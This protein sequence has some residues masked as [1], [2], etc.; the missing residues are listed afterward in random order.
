MKRISST[1]I[2]LSFILL[3]IGL[4]SFSIDRN[5]DSGIASLKDSFPEENSFGMRV[6]KVPKKAGSIHQP[7]IVAK[8]PGNEATILRTSQNEIK[9]FFVNRPGDA[10]KLMSVSSADNGLSWTAARKEFDLPGQA[11]YANALL[12]DA[13]GNLH[14]IFHIFGEGKNGYR[15]RHLNLWYCHTLNNGKDWSEPTE[16]YHG[17]VG[18]I[19]GFIQLKNK[20]FLLV[21]A[22]AI[23]ARSQKPSNNSTDYGLHDIGALYSDN[24]GK[25][26]QSSEND[27]KIPIESTQ[28]TRYG[29][30]EP[31]IIELSDGKI[32]MLI[33]TNKG[34]TYQSFSTDSGTRWHQPEPTKFISSDSPAAT[35]RLA[36][37][38]IV[39][40]W[41][42]NQ[43]WDNKR[44][45]ALGG[46]ETLHAAISS[47]EGKTWKGF[48]EVL[49][50]P[51]TKQIE[52]GDR[53]TA[54]PSAIQSA[55]GKIVLVSGQAEERAIVKFDPNWLEQT[56]QTDDFSENLAKW[57]FFNNDGL[58]SMGSAFSLSQK[59]LLIRK[60]DGT[61][62]AVWNF[63]IATKGKLLI[64]VISNPGNKGIILAITDN[65]SVSYDSL[66]S[67]SAVIYHTIKPQDMPFMD[68]PFKIRLT[69]DMQKGKSWLYLNDH[70]ITE[71]PFERNTYFGLNYLR[72]GIPGGNIQDH[73]GFL[74]RSVKMS[75]SW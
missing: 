60:T 70:L 73:N 46:R 64:N 27:L 55:D 72:L 14:C 71:K 30:V 67:K 5:Y 45:Y 49:T 18:S 3:S 8:G 66:A 35:L 10:N 36:D 1:K 54:Y 37:N 31:N 62:D 48:R 74:V 22:K 24:M 17:Y 20:R 69:W 29:G 9:V 26:W 16:I 33:R 34:V 13:E 75:P 50:S 28:T 59:G 53:G 4:I 2:R 32:W 57:T 19:R 44:T 51:S 6:R 15:G 43:R 68:K 65:F 41:N 61:Q 63:P 11:Y 47:D 12:K 7:V 40:F 52:K 38:R 58:T 39:M 42:S 21:F 25:S 23:P 56:T